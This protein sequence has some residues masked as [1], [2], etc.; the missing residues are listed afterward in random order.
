MSKTNYGIGPTESP[1][2]VLCG[3]I[4]SNEWAFAYE[5]KPKTVTNEELKAKMETIHLLL[6]ML[7]KLHE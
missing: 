6:R 5:D 1:T 4:D 7:I 2:F 3:Y